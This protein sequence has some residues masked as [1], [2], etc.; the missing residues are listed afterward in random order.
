MVTTRLLTANDL[1][2]L[3]PDAPYEL[4]EGELVEVMSPQGRVHGRVLS[5]LDFFLNQE[6]RARHAGE[7]LV[8]DVGFILQRN[9][10]TVLGPD[11]AY[12]RADR[13]DNAGD[14]FLE[15][16]PDLAIEVVSPS[17]TAPEIARK[18]QIYLAAGSIEVWVVRPREQEIV[19]HPGE[20]P[21]EILE[22]GDILETLVFPN[23]TLQISDVFA[24]PRA[25]PK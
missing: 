23:F 2:R 11:L 17:N 19:V 18:V 3:G 25:A 4:I 13:L 9:P 5:N 15:L 20:A 21:P 12:V 24:Q 22:I 7:L 16:A 8:G 10:D 6:I 1:F 14:V